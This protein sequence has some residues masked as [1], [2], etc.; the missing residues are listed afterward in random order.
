MI[1][2]ITAI[3]VVLTLDIDLVIARCG[4]AAA[5]GGCS[6]AGA[7]AGA[8]V[9]AKQQAHTPSPCS[10]VFRRCYCFVDLYVTI[11][12]AA[13]TTIQMI[14]IVAV[15]YIHACIF[16]IV[17]QISCNGRVGCQDRIQS[18]FQ[19]GRT[20][21]TSNRFVH[22]I[23]GHKIA[24]DGLLR[25]HKLLDAVQEGGVS[26]GRG[27]DALIQ[28]RAHRINRRVGDTTRTRRFGGEDVLQR[29]Q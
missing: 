4:T 22:L 25:L 7:A 23:G 5:G 28:H 14:C 18:W 8:I 9:V 10:L 24:P 6:A 16:A 1:A 15:V 3:P 20:Y 19:Y 11:A 13:A 29:H 21:R 12:A 27:D 17:Q 2:A 26:F